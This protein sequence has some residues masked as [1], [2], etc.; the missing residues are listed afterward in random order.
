VPEE[1]CEF[2]VRH[3]VITRYGNKSIS[4][5]LGNILDMPCD[6]WVLSAFQ[7][8]YQPTGSSP[9]ASVWERFANESKK[10]YHHN[11]YG[12]SNRIIG[13]DVVV[14]LPTEELFNQNYP[15]IV[16]H[17]LDN[18]YWNRFDNDFALKRSYSD[19]LLSLKIM[20]E[21]G[22]LGSIIGM[23]L[24][25]SKLHGFTI[26]QA[27]NAQKIFA[28]DALQTV[29]GL[30]EVI[31]C[32]YSD[33]D[34]N[35]AL[36]AYHSLMNDHST[37]SREELQGWV[38]ESLEYMYGKIIHQS[39]ESLE[40]EVVKGISDL[41]SMSKRK[42]ININDIAIQARSVVEVWLNKSNLLSAKHT[43][44]RKIEL[45]VGETGRPNRSGS[46]L[47]SLRILG[48]TASHRLEAPYQLSSED[49]VT[50]FMAILGMLELNKDLRDS[51]S[52][53]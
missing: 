43:M 19:L 6:Q 4:L 39:N 14:S 24:L 29:P 53:D 44:E 28:E 7:G 41:I 31:I 13:N 35:S 25:G 22:K 20:A 42:M 5:Y 46:Y 30:D 16:L 12:E 52:A 2:L 40:G 17:L 26:E 38:T 34:A 50:I 49:L 32:A 51:N 48:N 15:L 33:S 37:I 9:W 45:I 27:L 18:E 36:N 21:S 1:N 10:L 23:P 3:K 11:Y 47:H 8:D